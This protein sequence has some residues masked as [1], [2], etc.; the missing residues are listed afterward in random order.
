MQNNLLKCLCKFVFVGS[1]CRCCIK[2]SIKVKLWRKE[3]KTLFNQQ[4]QTN[5]NEEN[6]KPDI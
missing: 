1:C 3:K 5:S 4:M 6:E 2:I